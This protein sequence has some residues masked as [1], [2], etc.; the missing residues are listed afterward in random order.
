MEIPGTYHVLPVPDEISDSLRD[1]GITRL[2]VIVG[3]FTL[4]RAIQGPH[5]GGRFIT[6]NKEIMKNLDAKAGDTIEVSIERDPDPDFIELAVEFEAVLDEDEV[7]KKRWDTFT[8]GKQRS[9]AHFVNGPKR[10]ETR[11]KRSLEMAEK[12]RT[13]SL[14][15]DKK[16]D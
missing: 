3:Q 9:L 14:Y 2:L 4:R 1:E 13:Y 5:F 16:P 10:S 6:L 15:G 11:I 7:A 8:P 12:I